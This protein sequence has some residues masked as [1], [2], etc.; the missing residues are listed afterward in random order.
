MLQPADDFETLR[1]TFRWQ[2]PQ[3]FN[4]AAAIC[5]RHA[6]PDNRLALIEER[7]PGRASPA[8]LP[9][10]AARRQP[11]RERAS[12]PPA[13]GRGER[14]GILLGQRLETLLAHLAVYK[15]GAIAV[16]LFSLFGPEALGYPAGRQRCQG[17]DHRPG[18]RRQ[19]RGPARR[20][21]GAA[22]R[23]S[24]PMAAGRARS[25]LDAAL[26]RASDRFTNVPTGADDP[27]VLIYTSG[28]TGPP[29]GALHA[30]R[31]LL[32][33]LPGVQLPHDFFPQPGDRFWT[34]ADWAW[35]GGL[36][37]VLMPSSLLR[38]AGG[39]RARRQVRSRGRG[40]A[41]GAPR[42]Q[43]RVSA[44]DRASSPAPGR[45]RSRTRSGCG[46]ARSPP[47]ARSSATT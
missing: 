13:S 21:A 35:I 18:R 41:D 14:V 1:R 9:R 27:A 7:A 33:H 6:G 42:G 10:P 4:L 26:A 45:R 39:R 32:G 40:P 12:A 25:D 5:D 38:R 15:L 43:E 28:T 37:D 11:A 29:K 30:H 20:P 46:C 22:G 23:C 44:A 19:A 8:R 3:A 47:A 24:R 31:V 2:I 17:G 16:P 34:P 36:M